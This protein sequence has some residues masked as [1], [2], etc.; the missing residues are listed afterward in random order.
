LLK[1]FFSDGVMSEQ[2]LSA[3]VGPLFHLSIDL[4]FVVIRNG[5]LNIVALKQRQ[6]LA[7]LHTIGRANF[8]LHNSAASRGKYVN[9]TRGVR[10]DMRW[11]LQVFRD[12]GS[13]H[14][15]GLDSL[16]VGG[17]VFIA[18]GIRGPRRLN[19]GARLAGSRFLP[20]APTSYRQEQETK[21]RNC[22]LHFIRLL[23]L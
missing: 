18:G 8:H 2:I 7:F 23:L 22:S 9:Y 17:D 13:F 5:P 6:Q 4:R 1:I 20:A 14:G 21:Y 10:F 3:R 11:K 12:G 19:F 16:G 15:N